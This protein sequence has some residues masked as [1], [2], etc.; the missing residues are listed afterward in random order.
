MTLAM[1]TNLKQEAAKRFMDVNM[2][3]QMWIQA[4]MEGKL[5]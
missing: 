4:G 3:A 2:L 5:D 1:L